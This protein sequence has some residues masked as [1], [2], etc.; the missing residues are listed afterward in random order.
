M[1]RGL[2]RSAA[3]CLNNW[4]TAT[5]EAHWRRRYHA[6]PLSVTL[7]IHGLVPAGRALKRSG[8]KPGD[9]IYVMARWAISAA[10]PAIHEVIFAWEAQGMPTIWSNAIYARRRVFYKDRRRDL[11]SSAILDL[12]DGFDLRSWSHSAEAK[13]LPGARVDLEE[14]LPDSEEL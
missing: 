5:C 13:Q 9:W 4:I 3:A 11:A 2:P 12:S 10:G 8:A 6:R 1:R 14:A 7:G